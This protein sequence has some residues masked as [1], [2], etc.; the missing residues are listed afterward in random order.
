MTNATILGEAEGYSTGIM[1]FQF[2]PIKQNDRFNEAYQDALNQ[3]GGTCLTDPVI[4][5]KWFWAYVLNGYGFS[6]KGT[7]V[8]EAK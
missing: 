7:V 1:L 3:L 5:E 6:V 4:Q 8:K 2:I